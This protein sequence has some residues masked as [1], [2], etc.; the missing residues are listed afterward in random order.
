MKLNVKQF[1]NLIRSPSGSVLFVLSSVVLFSVVVLAMIS[2]FLSGF[3]AD[4]SAVATKNET[5]KVSTP[6]ASSHSKTE[7]SSQVKENKASTNEKAVQTT[8]QSQIQEKVEPPQSCTTQTEKSIPQYSQAPAVS[9]Q[10][11]NHQAQALREAQLKQEAENQ[12]EAERLRAEYE[13]KGYTVNFI[14]Q[15]GE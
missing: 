8:S 1:Q 3:G 10:D 7:G 11:L 13:S 2:V 6:S 5:L 14:Y 15:E 9:E 12:R 4:H